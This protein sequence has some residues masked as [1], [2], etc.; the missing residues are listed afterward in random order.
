LVNFD[1]YFLAIE[2]FRMRHIRSV[3]LPLGI[4][5]FT[6][7]CEKDE[8]P[9]LAPEESIAYVRY[10]H[11][12][13]DTGQTDWRPID[14]LINSPPAFGLTFRGFTPYQAMG[15]GARHIRIFPTSTDINVTSVPIIDTTLTF[16]ANTY[17]TLIW[18]GFARSGQT[19]ADRLVLIEDQIP[20]VPAG[21]VSLRV[22][23]L[24][25]DLA[26]VDVFA[27]PAATTPLPASPLVTGIAAGSVS[28]YQ[29]QTPGPL[30]LQ[31]TASGTRSP[32]L[33]QV[34][35]PPGQAADP[36]L[37]LTA[38]GGSTMGGSAITAFVFRASVTGSKAPQTTAFRNPGIVY[39][40]DRHPPR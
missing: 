25:L 19:P 3:L 38:V 39:L 20:D 4:V 17:Y 40:V 35:A 14:A 27:T 28:P 13:P 37:N 8:G 2:D 36:T 22:V 32:I 9:F 23:N 6:G 5:A 7:A 26:S 29:T 11:A 34:L 18:T 30:A 1:F 16:N 33:A 24:G 10:V 21:Q 31:V 15:S 12:V